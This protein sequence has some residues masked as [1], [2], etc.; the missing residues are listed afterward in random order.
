MREEKLAPDPGKA[1][2]TPLLMSPNSKL[3]LRIPEAELC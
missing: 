2:R 1:K 3:V